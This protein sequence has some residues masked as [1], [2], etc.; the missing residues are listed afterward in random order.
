MSYYPRTHIPWLKPTT[1][2]PTGSVVPFS[3]MPPEIMI[4]TGY[5]KLFLPHYTQPFA[6]Y[7]LE[8]QAVI[9]CLDWWW[10]SSQRPFQI[11]AFWDIIKLTQ[12][13]ILGGAMG[14]V[15]L[16]PLAKIS[17]SGAPTHKAMMG[18]TTPGVAP[19]TDRPSYRLLPMSRCRQI[20]TVTYHAVGQW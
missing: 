17:E 20:S 13:E 3:R 4:A 19:T 8:I 9:L 6:N 2:A 16:S 12:V 7:I 5:P 14:G 10:I 11:S 1:S 15:Y 18:D